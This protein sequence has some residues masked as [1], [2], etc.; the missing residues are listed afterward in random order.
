MFERM[1]TGWE[2]AKQSAHVLRQDKELILFPLIS[3]VACLLALA[4]FA[5]PAYFGGLF[6]FAVQE[7]ADGA[8]K[9]DVNIGPLYY[10]VAFLFYF[11]NYFIVI[12]FNS[13]LVACAI[14]RLKGGN[15]N[16]GDGFGAAMARLPQIAGWAL[17]AAT[18]GMIL[19][20]YRI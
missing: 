17:V 11:V 15:P 12:F 2:L 5:V 1:T 13:A 10:V 3:G 9:I 14:I 18:V 4:S 6:D 16:L 20:G 7:N 19:K 8:T